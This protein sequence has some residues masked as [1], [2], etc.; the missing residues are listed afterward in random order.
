[1][2]LDPLVDNR[3]DSIVM[4]SVNRSVN[5]NVHNASCVLIIVFKDVTHKMKTECVSL[6]CS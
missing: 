5:G 2:R 1:M 6:W 3:I 4:R